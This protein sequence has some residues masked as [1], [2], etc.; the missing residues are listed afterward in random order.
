MRHARGIN[1]QRWMQRCGAGPLGQRPS[2]WGCKTHGV[3]LRMQGVGL[4]MPG[5]EIEV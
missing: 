3:G 2:A 1:L 4:R 5:V